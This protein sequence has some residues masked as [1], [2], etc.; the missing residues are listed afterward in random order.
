M[1]DAK[2]RTLINTKAVTKVK[3]QKLVVEFYFYT[4][5][6]IC[7]RLLAIFSKIL[8]L[9]FH[10]STPYDETTCKLFVENQHC[11]FVFIHVRQMGNS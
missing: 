9:F 1:T 6:I 3:P 8:K 10:F 7:C 11:V 5:K 2:R 4:L